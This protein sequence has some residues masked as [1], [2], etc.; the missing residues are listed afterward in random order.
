MVSQPGQE[1]PQS[2]ANRPTRAT[3]RASG[4]PAR[5]RIGQQ[6]AVSPQ[7]ARAGA[8]PAS[9]VG[10]LAGLGRRIEVWITDHLSIRQRLSLWYATL[11]TVILLL[12]SVVVYAVEQNQ[13]QSSLMGDIRN[14]ATAIA[15]ALQ[16]E[17]GATQ[18]NGGS[19][20]L[21][22]PSPTTS[23]KRATPS[24]QATTSPQATTQPTATV[25]AGQTATPGDATGTPGATATTTPTPASTP[26]PT[27]ST[28]IQNRLLTVP[29][30]L[31]QLDLGFEVLDTTGR[32]KYLAPSLGNHTL[33]INLTVVNAAI[34]GAPGSYAQHS[35]TGLLE[36]YVQPIIVK[37]PTTY[38]QS[39]AG[40]SAI[41]PTSQPTLTPTVGSKTTSTEAHGVSIGD[42]QEV[43]GLVLVAK[44]L[45]EVNST[46][47]TLSRILI[48]GDLFAIF[49]ASL[50]GW[51]IAESGLRPITKVTRAARAIAINAHA[52]GLGTRVRYRGPRDEV[53]ELVSTFNDM[54]ASIEQVTTAQRRFVADASHELRA[55]LTTIKGSL[56]FLRRAH[57]LP[58]HERLAMLEDAYAES[59]RMATL[60][61]DLLLLARVDAAASARGVRATLLD[62]QLTGRREPVELDQLAMEVFRY[63]RAQLRARKKDI[64]ITVSNLE[65]V[66]VLADPG[67]L[68]QLALILLDNAIKYTPVGGKIR[69]AVTR[70][71][72]RAAFSVTDTGIGIDPADR[73]H[74]FERFYRAD[75]A[76]ER[77]EYGSG[78][79]LAIARWIVEAHG[80]EISVHSQLGQ[81][82]TFTALLPA[83][84]RVGERPT[85][86]SARI[87]GEQRRQ[88]ASQGGMPTSKSKVEKTERATNPPGAG[89]LNPLARLTKTISR[90]RAG[91]DAEKAKGTR[92]SADEVET[93]E[94]DAA[95]G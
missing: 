36:V 31:G 19:N 15:D 22:T 56:D 88:G 48:V 94:H 71:G 58:D 10:S 75:R 27:T 61:S 78:L 85:G 23:G 57:D 33:P 50:V 95:G 87:P 37:T 53:G 5:G 64:V 65:P 30:I 1:A 41:T 16:S 45:D 79:G 59:E 8:R 63:G 28:I 69:L 25:G 40:A 6:Q 38:G 66:T 9:S 76:R 7:S 4:K 77:D 54:L 70:N 80:G 86:T 74:I 29:N 52:A 83:V 46:L 24:L 21:P 42:G 13:L 44:P 47:T 73:P 55:P 26:D 84:R 93:G 11:L 62:E 68:R 82:S 43:I 89:G 81:G 20:V 92:E 2:R 17:Q 67:Q 12:F 32:L 35:V 34:H 90:P 51:L 3:A 72:A 60:V 39:Q 91:P 49:F 14:R 18:G